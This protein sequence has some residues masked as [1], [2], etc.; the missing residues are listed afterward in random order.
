MT[1]KRITRHIPE[2]ARRFTRSESGAQ[3]V[4]FAIL[5]PM[6]LLIFAVI[7]EGGRLMWSYQA[8]GSGV[9][10][11][12]RYLARVVPSDVCASGASVTAWKTSVESIVRDSSTTGD[13]IFP[14]SITI[15]SV[16]PSVTCF[17]GAYRVP[18]VG[19]AEVTASLTITFPFA[20]LFRLA[21]GDR[22]TFNTTVTDQSRIFG[23]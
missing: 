7:I 13:T 20:G 23:T 16:T 10:D 5:L 12:T 3:L 19:V 14:S 9:R 2:T 17:A 1:M 21:G 8:T 11:A 15:N 18:I 22:P 6:L 4:E